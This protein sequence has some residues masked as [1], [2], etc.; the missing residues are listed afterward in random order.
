MNDI[1]ETNKPVEIMDRFIIKPGHQR[2]L[3]DLMTQE[4]AQHVQSRGLRLAGAWLTPPFERPDADSELTVVWEYPTLGAL[5]AARMAEEDDPVV[6]DIWAKAEKMTTARSRQL[7]RS[8]SMDLPPPDNS[9]EIAV[10]LNGQ[11]TILFV[12]PMEALSEAEESM[13]IAAVEGLARADARILHSRAGFHQEYS[14]MPGHF[15]WDMVASKPM[16][17]AALLA[18]LPGAAEIVEAVTLGEPLDAG[19][20]N[21]NLGGT[22]RTILVRTEEGLDGPAVD[23]FEKAM[24]DTPRYITAIRNWRVTRVTS[25]RGGWTLCLEQEVPDASVFVGDYLNHPYHWAVV[26][27]LFHPDA[28]ERLANGFCHTLYPVARSVLAEI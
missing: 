12:R 14:F 10:G 1:F 8:W 20:R 4:Y 27:R 15:T 28:P 25:S 7:A 21:P 26:E 17:E 16:D 13:W 19:L 24:I 18:A 2:S 11:R 9:G 5:W 3:H 6:R 23:A 22:K